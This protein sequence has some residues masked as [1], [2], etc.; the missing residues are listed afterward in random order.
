[1]LLTIPLYVLRVALCFM[2]GNVRCGLYRGGLRQWVRE[3]G[4]KDHES[5]C[6]M[7][8]QV[9]GGNVLRV[10]TLASLMTDSDTPMYLAVRKHSRRW[11][12]RPRAA[13]QSLCIPCVA[14]ASW[15][16]CAGRGAAQVIRSKLC[17]KLCPRTEAKSSCTTCGKTS[18]P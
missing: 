1:M 14:H 10:R 18:A 7:L 11:V 8:A 12:N 13:Q 16:A 9:D 5:S 6:G 15:C 17:C 3:A 2:S 4:D